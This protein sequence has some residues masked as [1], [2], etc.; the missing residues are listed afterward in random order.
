MPERIINA[1]RHDWF[2]RQVH[3]PFALLQGKKKAGPK[4]SLKS[5]R[6]GCL[7][8]TLLYGFPIV[9]PQVRRA[10]L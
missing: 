6:R 9:L 2:I 3:Q 5:F 1:R 7:K 10:M 8:G 4:T